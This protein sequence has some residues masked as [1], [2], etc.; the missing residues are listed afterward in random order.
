MN[1]LCNKKGSYPELTDKNKLL[2]V[3]IFLLHNYQFKEYRF[4]F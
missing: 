1:F 2:I 3:F 4:F